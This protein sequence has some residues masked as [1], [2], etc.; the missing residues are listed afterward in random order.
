MRHQLVHRRSIAHQNPHRPRTQLRRQ[1][2]L[3][4]HHSGLSLIRMQHRLHFNLVA[5]ARLHP[6]HRRRLQHR[7]HPRRQRFHLQ[8]HP[9]HLRLVQGILIHLAKPVVHPQR[10][11]NRPRE[12]LILRHDPLHANRRL[13]LHAV[14][15]REPVAPLLS[16]SIIRLQ[17]LIHRHQHRRRR[18]LPVIQYLKVQRLGFPNRRHHLHRDR[19]HPRQRPKLPQNR[20]SP[21]LR[22]RPHRLR[23]INNLERVQRR[24]QR[25]QHLRL[26][27][28]HLHRPILGNRIPASQKPL[29]VDIRHRT[30]PRHREIPPH[31]HRAHRTPRHQRLRLHRRRIRSTQPRHRRQTHRSKPIPKPIHRLLAEPPKHQRSLHR[32]HLALS[33]DA[34]RLGLRPL[35][36]RRRRPASIPHL[37]HRLN[38]RYPADRLLRKLPNP[39]TQRPH[40][41]PVDIHR[42]PAHP[43][44]HARVLRLIPVQPRQNHVLPRPQGILQHPQNLHLHRLRVHPFENRVSHALHSPPYLRQREE[45]RHCRS[46][47]RHR[48]RRPRRHRTRNRRRYLRL[49][50]HPTRQPGQGKAQARRPNLCPGDHVLQTTRTGVWAAQFVNSHPR[51]RNPSNT[52]SKVSNDDH[53]PS[54]FGPHLVFRHLHLPPPVHGRSRPNHPA[55][56]STEARHPGTHPR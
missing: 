33:L 10:R 7:C 3:H 21:V 9:R 6:A 12:E 28:R 46:S 22:K 24:R 39:V 16:R 2:H 40:Q 41:P 15:S 49:R 37:Q 25:S 31:Q 29:R 17:T 55:R 5:R 18:Q 35:H 36:P 48:N 44:H 50:P 4:P 14:L 23:R 32:P 38:R 53:S 26:R 13:S 51:P 30:S 8:L 11:I 27:H 20:R 45:F 34:R 42:A 19:N 56:P 54:A 52:R 43:R 1:L 47:C